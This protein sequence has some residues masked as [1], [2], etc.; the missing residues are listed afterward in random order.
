MHRSHKLAT[1]SSYS[2]CPLR[3]FPNGPFTIHGDLV[4]Y[5]CAEQFLE[6]LPIWRR[7]GALGNTCY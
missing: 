1:M 5:D 6:C 7:L 4:E 3:L 2:G